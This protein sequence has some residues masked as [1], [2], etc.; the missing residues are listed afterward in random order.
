[1]SEPVQRWL[2]RL[3]APKIAVLRALKLGD[4]LCAVPA[5]RSLRTGLPHARITLIG[6]PW[7]SAFAERYNAFLDDFMVFPG[8][9]GLPEQPVRPDAVMRV[10][11]KAQAE[12]YDLVG[13]M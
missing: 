13:Q 2:A 3:P 9:P 10:L 11:A 5:L 7:A 8:Y 12:Q 1:M 4:M 6:L